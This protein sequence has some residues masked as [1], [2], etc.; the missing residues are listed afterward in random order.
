MDNKQFLKE[1]TPWPKDSQELISYVEEVSEKYNT[2][3]N[4]AVYGPALAAIAAFNYTA[5]KMG[6]SGFQAGYSEMLFLMKQRNLENG[7]SVIDFNDLLYPQNLYK[8]NITPDIIIR[9][10]L[11]SLKTSARKLLQENNYASE[12]VRN[13]WQSI[14]DIPDEE[15]LE[16][17]G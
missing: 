3:Y 8:F 17:E 16:N 7:F 11:E 2:S 13:H 5:S 10:N 12:E 14:L 4:D 15:K 6:L 9:E 1:K